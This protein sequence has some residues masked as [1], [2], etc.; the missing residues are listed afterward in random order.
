MKLKTLLE[1]SL[2]RI[3]RDI[4]QVNGKK[5]L[6]IFDWINLTVVILN[7]VAVA[8]EKFSHFMKNVKIIVGGLVDELHMNE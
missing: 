7:Y 8:K 1:A 6:I 5:Y 3:W 4:N 2:T